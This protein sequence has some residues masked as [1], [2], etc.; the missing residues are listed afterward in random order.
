MQMTALGRMHII[1]NVKGSISPLGVSIT[2]I[3]CA[4]GEM[5]EIYETGRQLSYTLVL[6]LIRI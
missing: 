4:L 2:L 5:L 3:L 6:N 1:K